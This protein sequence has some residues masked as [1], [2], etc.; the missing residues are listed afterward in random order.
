MAVALPGSASPNSFSLELPEMLKTY[1]ERAG[2]GSM[3][4]V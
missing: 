2:A 1:G 4:G 3:V